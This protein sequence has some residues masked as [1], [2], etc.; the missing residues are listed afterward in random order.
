[1][2]DETGGMISTSRDISVVLLYAN[3][4][5]V[6]HLPN[7][8][9]N[10]SYLRDF[11]KIIV[12]GRYFCGPLLYFYSAVETEPFLNLSSKLCS[13]HPCFSLIVKRKSSCFIP[14]SGLLLQQRKQ[15]SDKVWSNFLKLW[16]NYQSLF[17]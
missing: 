11:S 14:A 6:R 9:S 10:L 16:V 8:S 7:W 2:E 3:H 5:N 15:I 4:W 13:T 17:S 12:V 1:M